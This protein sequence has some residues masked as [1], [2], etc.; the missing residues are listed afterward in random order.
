MKDHELALNIVIY[1]E[2]G[3]DD[4][5]IESESAALVEQ[6]SACGLG[7]ALGYLVL[8]GSDFDR[9][10]KGVDAGDALGTAYSVL[11][12]LGPDGEQFVGREKDFI[13]GWVG[14]DDTPHGRVLLLQVIA[15]PHMVALRRARQN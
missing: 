15:R 12:F 11:P 14:A 5:V 6:R 8:V 10:W 13:F 9:L 3:P 7:G 1:R 2:P 4:A